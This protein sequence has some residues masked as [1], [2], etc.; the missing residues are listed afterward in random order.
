MAPEQLEGREADAR[1]DIFAV[2]EVLY[3]M[4]TGR[5][6]FSGKTIASLIA[7]ILSVGPKPMT[8][9]APAMPSVLDR[10]VK[11]C[12]AKDPDDRWQS[13]RDLLLLELKWIAESGGH[14]AVS[15]QPAEQSMYFYAPLSF[16][17]RGIAIAEDLLSV[18]PLIHRRIDVAH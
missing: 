8:E 14:T 17:A 5:P 10:V 16:P 15:T 2:G 6:A 12:L 1:S 4:A 11:R 7:A 13:A 9:V 18:V 3:E